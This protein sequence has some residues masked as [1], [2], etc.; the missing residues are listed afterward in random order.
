MLAL[1]PLA[2]SVCIFIVDTVTFGILRASPEH[3]KH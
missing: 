1:Y 3:Y 2:E